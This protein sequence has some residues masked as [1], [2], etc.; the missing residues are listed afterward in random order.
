M[1]K[2]AAATLAARAIDI[3]AT[4][5][6]YAIAARALSLS[7]FG[8]LI[9]AVT[10][11]QTATVVAKHGLDE[12][13]LTVPPSGEAN[14]IAAR[15]MSRLCGAGVILGCAGALLAPPSLRALIVASALTL[16][17]MVLGQLV[18]AIARARH[19]VGFAAM[20]DGVVQPVTSVL[21]AAAAWH[22]ASSPSA[23]LLALLLS[24]V[25]V[26]AFASR[27]D[28]RTRSDCDTA[29][30][31][32]TGGSML[33][34]ALVQQASSS[35]DVLL[36]GVAA[37]AVEVARYGVAQKIASAVLLL[38]AAVT[39]AAIPFMRGLA[40][41]PSVLEE[42]HHVVTRWMITVTLPLFVVAVGTPQLVLRLFGASY[43]QSS[44]VPLILTMIAAYAY[45]FTG[46]VGYVM[47]F[48][49]HARTLLRM[50]IYGAAALVGCVALFVRFGAVGAAAG[51]LLGR[52]LAR[53]FLVVA[54]RRYTATST[55]DRHSIS[56]A[57][58]A[59]CGVA[60][61]RLALSASGPIVAAAAGV[62]VSLAIAVAVLVRRGDFAALRAVGRR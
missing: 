40:D 42:Y 49:N 56:M 17:A 9:L 23:F 10:V 53:A 29:S 27:I 20:L 62:V 59:V 46:P 34:V 37:S 54:A 13:L 58:A 47:V 38:Q 24:H 25:P 11:L 51:L 2:A 6:F 57:V 41:Q 18:I 4:Y 43:E 26:I 7:D 52:L 48:N 55:F 22:F 50:M 60:A 45:V 1:G 33:G 39:T 31:I 12:A 21:G 15:V 19:D 16:P 5:A 35:A 8:R 3:G 44:A 32:R 28:W 14:R 36:L 61:V 30:L